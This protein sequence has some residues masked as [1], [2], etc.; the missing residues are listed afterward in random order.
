MWE[1][2]EQ[3]D[4]FRLRAI[5][6]YAWD[7]YLYSKPD[8]AFYFAQLLYDFA[9]TKNLK[10]YMA[11]GLNIQGLAKEVQG[12]NVE[13]LIL[14][15]Q[16]K[17]LYVEET[18][19]SGIAASW[20][21]IGSIYENLGDYPRTLSCYQK[22]L[23]IYEELNKLNGMARSFNNIGIVYKVQEEH[24][25]ALKNFQKGLE[26]FEKLN[27]VRGIANSKQNIGIIHYELED[28]PKALEYYNQSLTLYREL[29]DDWGAAAALNNIGSLYEDQQEYQKALEHFNQSLKIR[30][31]LSDNSGISRTMHNIGNVYNDQHEY[32]KAIEWCSSGLSLGVEIEGV[33][34]QR[35]ACRC[36]YNAYKALGQGIKALEFHE[37]MLAWDDSLKSVETFEMLRQMEFQSKLLADSLNSEKEMLQV[38]MTHEEELHRKET[39]KNVFLGAGLFLL[40]VAG[41]LYGRNRFIEKNRDKMEE[42]KNRFQTLLLNILPL[43]VAEELNE[44]GKAEAR[45]FDNVSVMFTDFKDFTESAAKLSA[46]ELVDEINIC[47]EAFDDIVD[48]YGVEKIKTIGDA[49]MAAGGLPKQFADS[50]KNTVLAAMEMQRFIE[51]RKSKMDKLGKP[52]F[53]MRVGIHTGSVVAGIVGVKKFQYDL[54]G[55]T[56][57]TASR[58]ESSG[59][60]GEV[61]VSESTF[62]LV[63][64]EFAFDYRG[65]I[66]AKGKGRIKMYFLSQK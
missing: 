15:E 54:W 31:A 3:S 53:Q 40:L 38:K 35:D 28:Y 48:K 60:V 9:N 29:S 61:N 49:Y 22:S 63:K 39:T 33:R 62:N 43:E 27:D 50:A 10:L 21:N 11:D 55:D 65:E 5:G 17:Q 13:A 58:M 44:K 34:E 42:E 36:L 4:E 23:K 32:Q 19:S 64:D 25:Q 52:S 37:Q 20:Q 1:N 18:D 14:F 16:C 56:V 57:N 8:S 47:F 2:A 51:E 41:V 46:R 7:G 30:E 26:L 24:G 59:E 45:E 12:E 6:D 66:E